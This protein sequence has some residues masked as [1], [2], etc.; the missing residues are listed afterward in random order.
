MNQ[1]KLAWMR[2]LPSHEFHLDQ[3]VSYLDSFPIPRI[4]PSREIF[5]FLQLK[6]KQ[7]TYW[8]HGPSQQVVQ[9]V[10]QNPWLDGAICR[11]DA[12]YSPIPM[13]LYQQELTICKDTQDMEQSILQSAIQA[14]QWWKQLSQKGMRIITHFNWQEKADYVMSPEGYWKSE[15][16]PCGW[17][18]RATASSTA[19][20]AAIGAKPGRVT[21]HCWSKVLFAVDCHPSKYHNSIHMFVSISS[22][23]KIVHNE[24]RFSNHAKPIT[25]PVRGKK[26]SVLSDKVT[27]SHVSSLQ[28]F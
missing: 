20:A 11:G 23:V 15:P 3:A 2:M 19:R 7:C 28:I 5:E 24:E 26:L 22:P 21:V 27:C 6:S 9:S 12:L 4:N 16:Y 25:D 8:R 14:S 10:Q 17:W 13:P 1:L 18:R